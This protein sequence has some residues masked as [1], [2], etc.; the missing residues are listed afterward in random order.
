MISLSCFCDPPPLL[1]RHLDSGLQSSL[2][3]L[4]SSAG[5]RRDP[6]PPPPGVPGV[7]GQSFRLSLRS[8]R[9]RGL[10]G[11]KRQLLVSPCGRRRR[12]K[13]N[14]SHSFAFCYISFRGRTTLPEDTNMYGRTRHPDTC[15]SRH[16]RVLDL[17]ASGKFSAHVSGMM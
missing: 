11:E 16:A 14:F 6:D 17:E 13:Q 8:A 9:L 12:P 2:W 15:Q 10:Q 1:L 5:P 7:L 3:G 4:W